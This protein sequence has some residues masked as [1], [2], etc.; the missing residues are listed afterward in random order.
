MRVSVDGELLIYGGAT[1]AL[2]TLGTDAAIGKLTLRGTESGGG[3]IRARR[4][5]ERRVQD[6]RRGNGGHERA[7]DGEF[8]ARKRHGELEGRGLRFDDGHGDADFDGSRAFG[9]RAARGRV[10]ARPLRRLPPPETEILN[11]S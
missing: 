2:T 7:D 6:F 11:F 8:L 3:R 9:V 1:A 4:R 10:R 5:V